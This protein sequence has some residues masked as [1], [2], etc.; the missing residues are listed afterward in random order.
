MTTKRIITLLIV[1]VIV[2]LG[3]F[4]LIG[5]KNEIESKNQ[6]KDTGTVA[7][8]VNVAS[9]EKKISEQNLALLGTTKAHK[10]IG[11]KAETQGKV[12]SLSVELGDKVRKG[13]VIATIDN[14]VLSL[15]L[16]TSEQ[17][18][19]DARQNYERYKNLYEGGAA[20][21]AQFDQ[22]KLAYETAENQLA[23]AKKELNNA[24]VLAPIDGTITEKAVEVGTFVNIG[25]AIATIVDVS[26][27]KVELK[28]SESDAYILKEGDVV[29]L[30]TSVY[31]GVS[32]KGKITFI[33]PNGDD[34]HNYPVEIALDNLKEYPLKAS[35]Y[36]NVLFSRKGTESTLQIPREALVGSVKNARVYVVGSNNLASLRPLTIS[37]DNGKY[38]EIQEGLQEGEKVVTT[39]QI[40]LSDSTLVNIIPSSK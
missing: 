22:Y 15:M 18:L 9:V 12:T 1:V 19:A 35:T 13:Q 26:K 16:S 40:N 21:K 30:S 25:S 11:I 10:V 3:A 7:V 37:R 32:Y 8:A 33:S 39:G 29:N 5:N 38:L 28:V 24:S 4:R 31:P 20:T 27:L 6:M 14:K 34:T 17:K 36:V 23:Q 2:G